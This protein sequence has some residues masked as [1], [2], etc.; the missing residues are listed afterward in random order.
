MQLQLSIDILLMLTGILPLQDKVERTLAAAAE[1]DD[2]TQ[3]K[4]FGE[5]GGQG[6]L[7]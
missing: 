3:A 1:G 7:S 6:L 5:V 2:R 4:A